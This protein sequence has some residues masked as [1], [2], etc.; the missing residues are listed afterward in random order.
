MNA[1]VY[2]QKKKWQRKKESKQK[3]QQLDD[4]QNKQLD[5][6]EINS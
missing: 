6:E 2:N 1:S 4:G 5:F 3:K